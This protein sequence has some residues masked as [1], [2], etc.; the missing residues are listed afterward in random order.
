M[1]LRKTLNGR[2]AE[3]FARRVFPVLVIHTLVPAADVYKR[4]ALKKETD[5]L[6][7]ERLADLQKELAELHDTFASQKAQWENEK[8]SV[9]RLSSLREEIESLHRQI[10][11]AQQ[12]YEMCIR[13]SCPSDLQQFPA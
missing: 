10:Q 3:F 2:S 12:K 5:H 6:S 4:Q 13:D 1:I 8:A 7:Q 11:D 9:D